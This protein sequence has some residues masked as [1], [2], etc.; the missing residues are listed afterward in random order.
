MLGLIYATGV[1]AQ[2]IPGALEHSTIS[3]LSEDRRYFLSECGRAKNDD[4]YD[5]PSICIFDTVN[6]SVIKHIKVP[7]NKYTIIASGRFYSD[8]RHIVL[9]MEESHKQEVQVWDYTTGEMVHKFPI[10]LPKPEEIADDQAVVPSYD[11]QMLAVG[12]VQFHHDDKDSSTLGDRD[13]ILG[14]WDAVSGT[15]LWDRTLKDEV[16]GGTKHLSIG[17]SSDGARL[18][19]LAQSLSWGYEGPDSNISI[20]NA[21]DGR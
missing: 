18:F 14:V 6:S 12:K 16:N 17:F 21:K 11:G 10:S 3:V 2:A 5:G 7:G 19:I 13:I 4:K 8:S 9:L 1:S 20:L 15:R